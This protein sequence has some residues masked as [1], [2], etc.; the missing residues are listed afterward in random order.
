MNNK[1]D[2]ALAAYTI[3]EITTLEQMVAQYELIRMLNPAMSAERYEM[4]LQGML[5]NGYRMVGVFNDSGTC[6]GLSGFWIN[7]K[8]YSGKYLEVDNFVVHEAYRALG[9]GKLLSD[10]MLQE[11]KNH[12]C[13]TVMLDAYVTNSNAHRFYF[14]EG[15]HVKSYHFYKSI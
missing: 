3:A 8:L 14:R 7:T 6:I 1:T 10:W 13:E 15:F 12:C 9:L 4:L 2:E 11:A 5:P